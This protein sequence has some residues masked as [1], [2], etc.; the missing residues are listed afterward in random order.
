MGSMEICEV[1]PVTQL[2]Q[3]R[4]IAQPTQNSQAR[5]TEA[6]LHLP[7]TAAYKAMCLSPDHRTV[8]LKHTI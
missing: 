3:H 7:K 8:K 4:N 2:S 1:C 5:Y 6:R